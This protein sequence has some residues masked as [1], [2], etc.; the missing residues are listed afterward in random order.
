MHNASQNSNTHSAPPSVYI[1]VL[2]FNDYTDT[3]RCVRSLEDTEYPFYSI[4]IVDNASPDKSG[5][6]LKE[7][8]PSHTVIITDHN[9]GY[10]YGNNIGIQHALSQKADYIFILNNDTIVSPD[11][12][13]T[14]L[15]PF[16]AIPNL[17]MTTCKILYERTSKQYASAGTI[18]SLLYAVV[19]LHNIDR[20]RETAVSYIAGCAMMV[21][22]TVFEK[23]GFLNESFFM[24]FE[25]VEYS[26][27]VGKHF[28][29]LYT[30]KSTVYHKSGGGDQWYN[31]TPFYYY[32]SAR[33]RIITF[34]NTSFRRFHVIVTNLINVMMKMTVLSFF[35]LAGKTPTVKHQM[36][37]MFRG[38]V[39]GVKGSSGRNE[40]Y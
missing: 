2:N 32:Y 5:E 3:C 12:V 39:D 20:D 7:T 10:A 17:G 28:M 33:N 25:D 36:L 4:V 27:R 1:I 6:K 38:F 22:R 37:A 23:V 9:G 40:L 29:L 19:P 34:G 31:Y 15:Q 24:Y 35:Y 21:R 13:K 8:F 18:N 11:T 26:L 30:P 16:F 14:L